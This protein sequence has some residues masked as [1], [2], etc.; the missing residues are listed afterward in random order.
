MSIS[1]FDDFPVHQ[2][3]EYVRHPATSDRNF[4]DRYYF[5]LHDSKGEVFAIF[6]LGQYPNLGVTDA[7]LC[8]TDGTRHH[9]VR[10][11]RPLGDRMNTRIGPIA[12]EVLE[13]LT[14][15]R[16]RCDENEWGVAM[17]VTWQAAIPA[18]EEPRQYLRSQGKVVFDTQRFAQLGRWSGTLSV[19]GRSWSVT[20]DRWTGSRDRSW[21]VRPVGEPESDG[22]RQGINA[23]GGM[24]NYFPVLF[25]DHALVYMLHE[26]DQGERRLEEAV[27]VWSDP[28]R[29]IDSLG[30]PEHAHEFQSGT[31]ILR[32]SRIALPEADIV[33]AAKPLLCNYLSIGTGYGLDAD[34]RHGM[35]QGPE[36]VVQ[37]KNLAVAEIKV[38]GQY[39]VVDQLG[40]FEYTDQRGTHTG[41]GLYEHGFFGPY[42][43]YGLKDGAAVAP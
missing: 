12:I 17:D 23:M 26:T 1:S 24:W 3:S 31:R 8:V 22:I 27:R 37:G 35:Y 21:G 39:G 25:E 43:R 38:L 4:Y 32:S 42:R 41:F 13:P 30:R 14:R 29:G 36:L 34:W 16:V 15:V 10:S 2:T 7:F 5:N 9:V 6:G 11:S 18:F 20:P 33:L 40:R 28:K 19:G